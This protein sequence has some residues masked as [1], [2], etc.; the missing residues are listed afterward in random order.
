MPT[1]SKLSAALGYALVAFIA[2]QYYKIAM[3]DGTNPGLLVEVCI[4]I[5]I[6]SGWLI[7]GRQTGDGYRNAMAQGLRTAAVMLAYIVFVFAINEML[8]RAVRKRYEDV[9]DAL[10]GIFEQ[11]SNYALTLLDAPMVILILCVGGMLAA[12]LAEWVGK[13]WP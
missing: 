10:L 13:R 8:R 3:P 2:S 6:I 5:G 12:C 9:G 4:G 1:A 11:A 7:M